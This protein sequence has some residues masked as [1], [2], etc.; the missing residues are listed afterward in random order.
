MEI[1][2]TAPEVLRIARASP[3]DEY[4]EQRI[5]AAKTVANTA[6]LDDSPSA[7]VG[8]AALAVGGAG[9]RSRPRQQLEE[10]VVAALQEESPSY[11]VNSRNHG[12][13]MQCVG[14]LAAIHL[15]AD[16]ADEVVDEADEPIDPPPLLALALLAS[17][18]SRNPPSAKR[19]LASALEDLHRRAAEELDRQAAALRK[20]LDV[21]DFT[22]LKIAEGE[23]PDAYIHRVAVRWNRTLD[24]INKNHRADRE[25]VDVLW[26][27]YRHASPTGALTPTDIARV[28]HQVHQRLL[29]PPSSEIVDIIQE[30]L[31]K[32]RKMFTLKQLCSGWKNQPPK[33]LIAAALGGPARD[34]PFGLP[35]LWILDRL[36]AE[37]SK[38]TILGELQ[39]ATGLPE[40]TSFSGGHWAGQLIF[41]L[42]AARAAAE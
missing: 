16:E 37:E 13:E 5:R 33:D 32:F 28:A 10:T 41:E 12:N 29:Q 8:L 17:L 30:G 31:A 4:V 27:M 11:T 34:N 9:A 19:R 3:D 42:A 24:V 23:S 15:L 22:A 6:A 18:N 21:A 26:W 14:I 39:G 1:E 2:R 7:I 38:N 40:T 36:G 20:R 25:E 35:L